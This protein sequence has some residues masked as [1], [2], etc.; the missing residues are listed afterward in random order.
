MPVA[1]S[2][3]YGLAVLFLVA[4]LASSCVSTNATMLGTAGLR[5]P[6]LPAQVVIYRSFDQV[7][8]PY[9][10]VAL[11]HSTGEAGFTSEAQL[12]DSMRLKAAQ[13]GANAIVLDSVVEPSAG[14]KVAAAF[15]GTPAERKGKA[16]AIFI[17]RL[18][19]RPALPAVREASQL[20]REL[21]IPDYDPA[22]GMT[23]PVAT[24]RTNPD[25][26]GLPPEMSR[27]R[28]V[29]NVVVNPDGTSGRS[30]IVESAGQAFD[31]RVLDA[32]RQWQFRPATSADGKP[33]AV[34]LRVTF[35]TPR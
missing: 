20:S 32:L 13:L 4:S 23:A 27:G 10:E 1:R 9:E 3:R 2:D 24:G 17:Q 11:L 26:S 7:R 31:Q 30:Q 22:A 34:I 21:S 35:E 6:L 19:Q 15:L 8:A 29:V 18:T 16:V 12:Y 5:P 28:V 33:I 14:A 25:L